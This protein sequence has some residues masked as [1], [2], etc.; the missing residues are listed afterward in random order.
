MEDIIT[1]NEIIESAVSVDDCLL[2]MVSKGFGTS[3]I[4][5]I[6][7]ARLMIL[8]RETNNEF[9]FAEFLNS[10]KTDN[11]MLMNMPKTIQ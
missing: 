8:N 6:V 5:G 7:M 11:S 10:I 3:A 1:D 9:E 2:N 4:N